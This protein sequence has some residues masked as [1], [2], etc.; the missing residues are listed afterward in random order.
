MESAFLVL[1]YDIIALNKKNIFPSFKVKSSWTINLLEL[2]ALIQFSAEMQK[3]IRNSKVNE[4][5]FGSLKS[6]ILSWSESVSIFL[7]VI[8]YIKNSLYNSVLL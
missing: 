7:G 2:S 1:W 8:L 3:P 5:L 4:G 6:T